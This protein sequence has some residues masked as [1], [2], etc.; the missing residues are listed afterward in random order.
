M[1]QPEETTASDAGSAEPAPQPAEPGAR[2]VLL[3]GDR[4]GRKVAI[5][6]EL[7]IGR[8]EACGLQLDDPQVS[9]HHCTVRRTA[10]AYELQ[11][12]GS[13]NGTLVN[14]VPLEAGHTLEY[15]D[16][17]QL[18]SHVVLLFTHYDPIEQQILQRQ[19]MEALGRMG[20]GIAHDF[21]NLLG[22]IVSSMD[23]VRSLPQEREL[24]DEDVQECL[25][26]VRTAASRAVD[27]TKQLL[28]FATR[29]PQFEDN[30]DLSRLCQEVA[31]LVRRTF[32]ASVEVRVDASPGLLVRGDRGQLH[33]ILMN[34]CV[35][36]R[37]A[38]PEG[39]TLS[40]RARRAESQELLGA[41]LAADREYIVLS[42]EDT[43]MGM[44][45]ETRRRA[46]DPFFTTKSREAGAGL[47]L[48]SV[49][50][51]T[52]AHGGHLQ[53]E[54]EVGKGSRFRLYLPRA[55]D[56][57]R[58]E[59]STSRR[60]R[61]VREEA[62]TTGVRILLADDEEVVR[63]SAARLLKQQGY[64]VIH[65]RDGQ[66][67]VE[68]YEGANPRPDLVVLDL[69]MP[70]L[71]GAQAHDALKQ[72]DPDVRVVFVSGYWEE[73]REKSLQERGALGFLRKPYKARM[74]H[75]LVADALTTFSRNDP[76]T[77]DD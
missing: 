33:Q 48:A 25:A 42:V 65:A 40:I 69:D 70:R 7:T 1:L 36:G 8:G 67:A 27:L 30:V 4:I 41:P 24:E 15:G 56:G 35:N 49:Y 22:A 47:G 31:Q 17:I 59:R 58:P 54:S 34:L 52:R 43:G 28:G 32:D 50:E 16:R 20:T 73:A 46:L 2:L 72:I 10:G 12:Q 77:G 9:R 23:F 44:D 14:G 61:A 74:L 38:M 5:R 64:E 21:N 75:E 68:E 29:G 45:A 76:S 53:I 57:A 51:I 60:Q 18:G 19:K 3:V 55:A 11:D 39:G 62:P 66:Q 26:D 63:R 71:D 6:D 37:D 13:R